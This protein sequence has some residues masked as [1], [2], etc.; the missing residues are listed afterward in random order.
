M[1]GR[2]QAGVGEQRHQQPL[3]LERQ[4]DLGEVRPQERLAPGDQAP[5]RAQ[6]D[7][8]SGNRLDL[9]QGQ[10]GGAR[11]R[12]PGRQ[13]DVAVGAVVVAAC[14]DLDVKGQRHAFGCDA[15]PQWIFGQGSVCAKGIRHDGEERN[16][17]AAGQPA[18]GST[19]APGGTVRR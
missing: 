7:R 19:T 10:L 12:V 16:D 14:C 3:A 1:L 6:L 2:D 5:Q 18:A 11:R 13:V 9:S 15:F 4:V 8:L 17:K